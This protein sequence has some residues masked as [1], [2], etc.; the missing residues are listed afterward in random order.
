[1]IRRRAF[2]PILISLVVIATAS[3]AFAKGSP[4][5]IV[6]SG[7]GL[8]Q[9]IEITDSETLKRFDPWLAQ[10][11]DWNRQAA[12]HAGIAGRS[13]EG[14]DPKGTWTT[15]EPPRQGDPYQVLV[16]MKWPGRRSPYDRGDLAMIY[17]FLYSRP[18]GGSGYV[19]LPGGNDAWK[20]TNQGTIIREGHDGRWHYAS[21][22]W[23]ELMQRVAG[24]SS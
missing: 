9:P 2:A 10:F 22:A 6:I 13:Y 5:R 15:V 14:L 7:G 12:V 16:Y 23:D 17:A 3:S 20:V 18:G 8:K 11:I 19:Y 21:R 24:P 1:M 4:D